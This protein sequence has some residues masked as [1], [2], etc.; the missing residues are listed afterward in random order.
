MSSSSKAQARLGLQSV[1]AT[2]CSL[3][4]MALRMTSRCFITSIFSCCSRRISSILRCLESL[5]QVSPS[6]S[7]CLPSFSCLWESPKTSPP[8]ASKPLLLLQLD[9]LLRQ[10]EKDGS[11]HNPPW[12]S[13][14]LCPLERPPRDTPLRCFAKGGILSSTNGKCGMWLDCRVRLC[15]FIT[16]KSTCELLMSLVLVLMLDFCCR[17]PFSNVACPFCRSPFGVLLPLESHGEWM[18]P[19]YSA[20]P[21]FPCGSSVLFAL[22]G[23]SVTVSVELSMWLSRKGFVLPDFLGVEQTGLKGSPSS[24]S[25][26]SSVWPLVRPLP[27][28]SWLPET[29]SSPLVNCSLS[30]TSSE[31]SLTPFVRGNSTSPFSVASPWPFTIP[32]CAYSFSSLSLQPSAECPLVRGPSSVF[33][34]WSSLSSRSSGSGGIILFFGDVPNWESIFRSLKF[35][36]LDVLVSP[37]VSPP[38]L[39]LLGSSSLAD[40]WMLSKE[41]VLESFGL[42]AGLTPDCAFCWEGAGPESSQ[43]EWQVSDRYTFIQSSSCLMLHEGYKTYKLKRSIS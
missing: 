30:S 36:S 35:G 19:L 6:R 24:C 42:S 37:C 27:K 41:R 10:V 34:S 21:T 11:E 38:M 18:I 40:E 1:L 31:C 12:E 33:G 22:D 28:T 5:M 13:W 32:S 23:S 43:I 26:S 14:G 39:D 7:R 29:T 16:G 15:D 2:C 25:E 20:T 4:M 3:S 8:V 9:V 17:S